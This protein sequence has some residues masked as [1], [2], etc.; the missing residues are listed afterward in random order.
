MRESSCQNDGH[1]IEVDQRCICNC[2][3][4]SDRES[5]RSRRTVSFW[6]PYGVR[7]CRGHLVGD[8]LQIEE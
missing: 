2:I 4:I 6:V 1:G 7:H 5:R 3:C 8:G